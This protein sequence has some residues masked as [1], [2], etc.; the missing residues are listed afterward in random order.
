ML[1]ELTW[2]Y[3]TVGEQMLES[4]IVPL[5]GAG[6]NRCGRPDDV[7]WDEEQRE[8][9]PDGGEL[10]AYLAKRFHYSKQ[11][12]D[13]IRISQFVTVMRGSNF[14]YEALH[15]LFD[16]DYPPSALHTFLAELPAL[17]AARGISEGQQVIITTNYDDALERAFTAAGEEFDLIWYVASTPKDHLGKFMH[18]PPGGEPRPIE[19]A[20]SYK[21]VDPAERTVIVKIHGAVQRNG[22]TYEHDNYVITEDDYINYL[23]QTDISALLPPSVIAKLRL[24]SFLFLGYSMSDWNLRVILRRLW[25]EQTLSANSWAIQLRPDPVEQKFWAMHNV[26]IKDIELGEYVRRLREAATAPA[27]AAVPS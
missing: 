15:G 17:R 5:L 16:A 20:N 2:H 3:Q 19:V 26:E 12:A 13:L 7:A 22:G 6:V 23:M 9:L 27:A 14:L 25:N 4:S 21:D 1:D 8:Y 10:A 18:R 24:S 11:V